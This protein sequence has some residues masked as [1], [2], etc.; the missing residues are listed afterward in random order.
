MSDLAGPQQNQIARRQLLTLGLGKRAIE[1]RIA[2]RQ[3]IPVFPGVY[4]LGQPPQTPRAWWMA[5]V[6]YA[7][8][9][10]V[11]SHRSAA[12]LH[13]I[14]RYEAA[15]IEVTMARRHRLPEIRFY[16][17]ALAS[18]EV[19]VIGGIPVTT[20]ARTL[21]D[22]AAVEKASVCAYA[23]NQLEVRQLFDPTGLQDLV[24]RHRGRRGI[25]KLRGLAPDTDDLR[26]KMERRLRREVRKRGWPKP[27]YNAPTPVPG[28][29]QTIDALWEEFALAVE[30]DSRRWH[31]TAAQ[32][33]EDRKRDRGARR[34]GLLPLRVTWQQWDDGM[35][36]IHERLTASSGQSSPA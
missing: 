27:R 16:R 25:R 13:E 28:D 9:G 14:L 36:E 22:I 6:L 24:T 5:A 21:I 26:S 35:D 15:G 34:A 8:P 17:N 11:L 20:A 1:V 32:F 7:G 23:L 18:D 29:F 31:D 2:R 33:E 12:V 30:L 19:T 4:S 3:L 10:A